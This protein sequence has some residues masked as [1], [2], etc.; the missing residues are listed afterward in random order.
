MTWVKKRIDLDQFYGDGWHSWLGRPFLEL[1]PSPREPLW[2]ECYGDLACLFSK[3]ISE[4]VL[5]E[6]MRNLIPVKFA[7]I[8]GGCALLQQQQILS[9]GQ[10]KLLTFCCC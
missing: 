5:I 7:G 1:T 2:G 10:Q 9:L 4:R 3:N 6:L 8:A